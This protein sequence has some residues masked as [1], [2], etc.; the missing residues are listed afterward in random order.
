V[1]I[2]S[3]NR[4]GLFDMYSVSEDVVCFR[5]KMAELQAWARPSA[6][7]YY[8]NMSSGIDVDTIQ[9]YTDGIVRYHTNGTLY[10]NSIVSLRR[11]RI[12]YLACFYDV[13]DPYP[14]YM[15]DND[16]V[17]PWASAL[18][19]IVQFANPINDY[20]A[21]IS[22]R[23]IN[24]PRVLSATAV[25]PITLE[26]LTYEVASWTPCGHVFT[27][28]ALERALERDARCPLCRADVHMEQCVGYDL[29][30]GS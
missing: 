25:C 11:T 30:T 8:D 12:P 23:P 19:A 13:I 22:P 29:E 27:H 24:I 14:V 21:P 3:N 5:G 6:S 20:Y 2:L 7:L 4:I 18:T 1:A 10:A 26:T 9:V 16:R 17:L 28:T 15:L